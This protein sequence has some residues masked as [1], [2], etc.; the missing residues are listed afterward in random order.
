MFV[1]VLFSGSKG[2]DAILGF[3]IFLIF[4]SSP[5]QG[6]LGDGKTTPDWPSVGV[7]CSI[8]QPPDGDIET[9]LGT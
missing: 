1:S 8:S 6:P 2:Q 9:T 3:L 5:F 4:S 7:L